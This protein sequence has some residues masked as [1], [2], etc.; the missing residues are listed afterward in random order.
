MPGFTVTNSNPPS[1][2]VVRTTDT[3]VSVVVRVTFASGTV[4]PEL[5][6][7]V[8]TTDAVSNCAEARGIPKPSKK[9]RISRLARHPN[10][11]ISHLQAARLALST[12]YRRRVTS[13]RRPN[14][15]TSTRGEVTRNLHQ[16]NGHEASGL[17]RRVS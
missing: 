11:R 15:S 2:P 6:F 13:W 1:W 14:N 5:S 17:Y 7:T 3:P 9:G 16:C 8:P 12:S 4:P 10:D